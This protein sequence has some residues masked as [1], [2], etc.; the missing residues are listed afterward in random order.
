MDLP[1]ILAFGIGG[2]VLNLSTI[3]VSIIFLKIRFKM[4][5]LIG[6]RTDFS[7]DNEERWQWANNYFSKA[8]LFTLPIF[9]IVHIV[10]FI[11]TFIY[12][13]PF[14]VM[15][16]SFSTS[17]VDHLIFFAV[18]EIL[19]RKRVPKKIIPTDKNN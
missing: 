3:V 4:N 7:C 18:V 1:F 14:W 10:L 19:G 6:Y 15:I 2:I 8:M 16:V 12:S 5:E 11:L 13:F 9:T 17:I